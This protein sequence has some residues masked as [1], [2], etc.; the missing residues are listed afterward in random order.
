[1]T[2][3]TARGGNNGERVLEINGIMS[4]CP[5]TA[6][7]LLPDHISQS[8]RVSMIPCSTICPHAQIIEGKTGVETYVTLCTGGAIEMPLQPEENNTPS[9]SAILKPM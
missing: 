9:V 4:R 7:L 2:K 3:Y 5:Y 1:M 6:P 8:M